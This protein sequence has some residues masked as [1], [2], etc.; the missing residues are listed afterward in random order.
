MALS[1]SVLADGLDGQSG[2]HGLIR[3]PIGAREFGQ[4][5]I[6]AAMQQA[7]DAWAKAYFDYASQAMALDS[8]PVSL[9]TAPLSALFLSAMTQ[10]TFLDQLPT[11]LA[12]FWMSPPVAF[13]G[14]NNGPV[15]NAVAGTAILTPAIA[16]VK[17]TGLAGG[18][19]IDTLINAIDGFTKAVVVQLVNP[20]GTPIPTTLL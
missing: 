6:D 8:K 5:A 16:T 9:V 12:A 15:I 7:A 11:N 4:A 10:M 2:I 19:A 18:N 17:I 3:N 1:V 20:S 13:A 14:V